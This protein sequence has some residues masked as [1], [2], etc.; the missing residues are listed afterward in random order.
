MNKKLWD[1]DS[2]LWLAIAWMYCAL[3]KDLGR[4]NVHI[5]TISKI[6][7]RDSYVYADLHITQYKGKLKH[8][9]LTHRYV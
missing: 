5:F 7:Y 8:Y 4:R 6:N 9:V 3:Q 1:F 2:L